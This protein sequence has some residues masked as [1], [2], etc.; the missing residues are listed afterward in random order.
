MVNAHCTFGEFKELH[1]EI[2]SYVV[3]AFE[4][5]NGGFAKSGHSLYGNCDSLIV[6][7]WDTPFT[8]TITIYLGNN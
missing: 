8:D 7:S 4:D 3:R 2:T 1:P 6:R 5:I